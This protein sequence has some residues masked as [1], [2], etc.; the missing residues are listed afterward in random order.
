MQPTHLTSDMP[1]APRRLGPDR[2][3]H[4]YAWRSFHA[5]G[6]PVAFGSDFPVESADPRRGIFAAVTTRQE[7][8]A[9]ELRP[10]QKLGRVRA[11]Q[12]FTRDAAFAMFA[13][14]ELGRIAVGARADLTVFD[15]N[16]LECSE[17]GLLQARVRMTVVDGRIVFDAAAAR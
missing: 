11:L 16:L 7:V 12:G 5:L 2:I 9:A 17:E 4:A 10:D 6:L 14:T 13:E 1:W 3:P 15:R 8:G